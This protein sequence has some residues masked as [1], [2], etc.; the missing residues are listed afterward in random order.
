MAALR[1]KR[2][3]GALSQVSQ[4]APKR[5]F[6]TGFMPLHNALKSEHDPI[7]SILDGFWT[8]NQKPEAKTKFRETSMSL[9]AILP[10]NIEVE[11]FPASVDRS[12]H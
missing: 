7:F 10:E 11:D 6:G 3:F 12:N 2:S 8:A 9:Q 4:S 1:T 5:V